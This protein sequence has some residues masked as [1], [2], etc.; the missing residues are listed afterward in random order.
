MLR[1]ISYPFA[2]ALSVLSDEDLGY[3]SKFCKNVMKIYNPLFEEVRSESFAKENLIIFVGRLN[4]IKNC[5]MFV[6]VAASLKQSGY[7]F[8]VAGDGGER[9]NLENLAK[10]LG[11]DVQ[12]LGNVSDIASLYK[13]AKVLLS[14]SN[15]E[16]LGN[17]LI[18]AINYDCVRV[19]T[20]TSGAKELIKDGFDGLLCEINDADQMSEKLANLLQDEAKMGEFVKNARARLDEFSVEQIYKKWLELLRLGGVK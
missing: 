5:E 4:K 9:S 15:F 11:A 16:G 17:T 14:C 18:E 12:F 10:N 3:Y 7:K 2:N 13:R 20:R 1:R 6:R 19:A 8:A